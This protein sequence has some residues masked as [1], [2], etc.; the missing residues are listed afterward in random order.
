MN[1]TG[2]ICYTVNLYIF[3]VINF[4]VLLLDCH[5]AA[6]NFCVCVSSLITY[7]GHTKFSW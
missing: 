4:H 1:E 5:S 2:Y 3:L 6:T 7:T